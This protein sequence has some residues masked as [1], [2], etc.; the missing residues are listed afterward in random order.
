[1]CLVS[2]ETAAEEGDIADCRAEKT[3]QDDG[4]GSCDRRA[5]PGLPPTGVPHR[6]YTPS[7]FLPIQLHPS[8][9]YQCI[10]VVYDKFPEPLPHTEHMRNPDYPLIINIFRS[11][12]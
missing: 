9:P 10:I 1:M 5:D 4:D 2:R 12:V 7:P 11:C 8:V 6:E 3:R